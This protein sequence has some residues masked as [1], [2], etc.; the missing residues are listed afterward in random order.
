MA[1]TAPI[2]LTSEQLQQFRDQGYLVVENLLNRRE[3]EEFL[4]NEDRP[5]VKAEWTNLLLHHK[6]QVRDYLAKHSNIA[7][8][9][10]QILEGMPRIVQTMFLP[11]APATAEDKSQNVGIALHQDTHYLPNEP[12]TLMAC[13]IAM[14]D[15]DE[16]NGGLCVVPGSHKGGLLSTHRAAEQQ[17]H[18][19]WEVE[20]DMIDPDGRKYKKKFYSFE[21]DGLD[22]ESILRLTV[23]EGGG[24][25]F[26][27]MLIHGSYAN[28]S[29]TRWRK[30]FAVHYIKDGTWLY[31]ADVHDTDPVS[32]FATPK[33]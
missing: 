21:I 26:H 15:T 18:V 11:K 8:V 24:V 5:E 13:W 14:N 33:P 30:A 3:V 22:Q 28:R 12:N 16:E 25:F 23:P 29:T 4:A 2:K 1:S 31:R 20:Y 32:R 9:A 27:G 7:G 10:S 17:E 19:S 6:N